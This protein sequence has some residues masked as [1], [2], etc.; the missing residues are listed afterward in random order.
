[1]TALVF[2]RICLDSVLHR[3]L[4]LLR[5]YDQP[6]KLAS[7]FASVDRQLVGARGEIVRR[8]DVNGVDED[9]CRRIQRWLTS[10]AARRSQAKRN[11]RSDVRCAGRPC[12]RWGTRVG[13]PFVTSVRPQPRALDSALSYLHIGALRVRIE[14]NQTRF[15]TKVS[16]R[17]I[18]RWLRWSSPPSSFRASCNPRGVITHRPPSTLSPF[19]TVRT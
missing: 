12:W 18:P 6:G 2:A 13:R 3:M 16:Q 10:G 4:I 1:M 11:R 7:G 9:G 14:C 17:C 8:R 15:R 5:A 19:G